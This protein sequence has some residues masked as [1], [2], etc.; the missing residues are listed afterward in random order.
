MGQTDLIVILMLD[1]VRLK[2][3]L[4]GAQTHGLREVET[5]AGTFH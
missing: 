5:D 1:R 2:K 3:V 4:D